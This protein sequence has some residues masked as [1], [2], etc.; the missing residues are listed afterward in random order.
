MAPDLRVDAD[1]YVLWPHPLPGNPSGVLIHSKWYDR[2][3]TFHIRW[4]KR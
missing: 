1:D 2:D 4:G 3:G